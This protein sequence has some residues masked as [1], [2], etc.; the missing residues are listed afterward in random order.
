M[1]KAAVPRTNRS[2][3]GGGVC[4]T[5]AGGVGSPGAVGT[6]SD[7][8]CSGAEGASATARLTAESSL[9]LAPSPEKRSGLE[10]GPSAPASAQGTIPSSRFRPPA[11]VQQS[12]AA[13]THA[14]QPSHLQS[15][16]ALSHRAVAEGTRAR[17]EG[18]GSRRGELLE[19]P[20]PPLPPPGSAAP[21]CGA[22]RLPSCWREHRAR[23]GG[24]NIFT[25][26]CFSRASS[27]QTGC[28]F[29]ALELVI[30]FS[31]LK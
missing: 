12:A 27:I 4:R 22:T 6:S 3:K 31:T 15:L 5:A 20:W 30:K 7:F 26:C 16:P 25:F 1:Q 14:V 28:G 18:L 11:L 19:T 13:A 8:R 10:C 21:P 29:K 2:P 9:G 23:T 24:F 17:P